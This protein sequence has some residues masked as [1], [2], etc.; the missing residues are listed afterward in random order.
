MGRTPGTPGGDRHISLWDFSSHRVTCE[1]SNLCV[2]QA[3]TSP[4]CSGTP[5]HPHI[6]GAAGEWAARAYG[7][8]AAPAAVTSSARLR[9]R[10]ARATPAG[11]SRPSSRRPPWPRPRPG[12]SSEPPGHC[13]PAV[14]RPSRG[15]DVDEADPRRWPLAPTVTSTT[16]SLERAVTDSALLCSWARDRVPYRSAKSARTCSRRLPG[17]VSIVLA[18]LVHMCAGYASTERTPRGDVRTPRR[19]PRTVT[20]GVLYPSTRS[21]GRPEGRADA[22][23]AS[24]TVRVSPGSSHR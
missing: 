24:V 16:P 22:G 4:G 15:T 1:W 6:E 10:V 14:G 3:R 8:T 17:D 19:Q 7:P 13:R 23:H 12:P 9:A 18:H 11:G 21:L 5:A 20:G 2:C